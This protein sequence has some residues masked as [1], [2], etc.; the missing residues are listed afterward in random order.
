MERQG[1]LLDS[2]AYRQRRIAAGICISGRYGH[3]LQALVSPH[4]DDKVLTHPDVG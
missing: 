2:A 4:V 3:T 1:N